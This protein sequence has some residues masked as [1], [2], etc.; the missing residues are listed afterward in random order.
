MSFVRTAK[1]IPNVPGSE[2]GC[3]IPVLCGSGW[4]NTWCADHPGSCDHTSVYTIEDT[5]RNKICIFQPW[6]HWA[7][8]VKH[9][10]NDWLTVQR[11]NSGYGLSQWGDRV[12]LWRHLSAALEGSLWVWT[13]DDPQRVVTNFITWSVLFTFKNLFYQDWFYHF[14]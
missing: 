2:G 5:T 13:Q 6:N 1:I 3:N 4:G 8:L 10:H 12:T 7:R 11:D 14:G 9:L